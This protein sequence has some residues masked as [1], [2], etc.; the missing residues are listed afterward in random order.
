M[1]MRLNVN[2]ACL[3]RPVAED[4][5]LLKVKVALFAVDV[6][7]FIFWSNSPTSF[8]KGK[9]LSQEA[10]YCLLCLIAKLF[11]LRGIDDN[12]A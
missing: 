9:T 4:I 7:I 11:C 2:Y 12:V 5:R 10:T 8:K 1:D 6:K 3:M